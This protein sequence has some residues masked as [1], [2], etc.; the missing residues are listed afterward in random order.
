[1]CAFVCAR[2]CMLK[3]IYSNSKLTHE[4]DRE[5][6]RERIAFSECEV[7][8]CTTPTVSQSVVFHRITAIISFYLLSFSIFNF[9]FFLFVAVVVVADDFGCN[10][11]IR[12]I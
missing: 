5:G 10:S 12:G 3:C 1:M 2:V 8:L 6:E 4:L 11:A 7:F 9:V